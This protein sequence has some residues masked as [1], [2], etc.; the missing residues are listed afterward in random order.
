MRILHVT[1]SL[2]ARSGGTSEAIRLLCLGL[3]RHGAKSEVVTLDSPGSELVSVN[4]PVHCLGVTRSGYGCSTN[5]VPWLRQNTANYDAVIVH[6][7]WQ[8]GNLGV[9]WI[10]GGRCRKS[11]TDRLPPYFVFPHGMLDPWFKR[12]YWMKHLKKYLYWWLVESWVLRHAQAVLFT[13]DEERV[14][15]RQSFR[16]YFCREA[17][18]PL[19]IESPVGDIAQQQ[20]RFRDSVPGLGARR[21][22][23]FLGRLHPKKGPELA[24]QAFSRL[25]SQL[26]P[27]ARKEWAL[28]MAGPVAGSSVDPA[29]LGKLQ[30]LA[31][32]ATEGENCGSQILFPG[33]LLG[34][35]K[36]GGF[37]AC[38]AFILPS[39]QENFG[40][41]V[42]EALACG[43]PVLISD[44]VN[45]WR[46]I[47]DDGAA[48]VENDTEAGTLALL[49]RWMDLTESDKTSM[50]AR[51]RS[52]FERRFEVKAAARRLLELLT[53]SL[54]QTCTERSGSR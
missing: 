14:L 37:H 10:L 36:W 20:K 35:A 39:H 5:L 2:R 9:W 53:E 42:V 15:A 13:A 49:K 22:W 30:A 23:L 33:L 41:A 21:F 48:F 11:A 17:V 43:K 29:Y 26:P 28:V 50:G 16:P 6:G 1:R 52:C 38:E 3:F 51:A 47:Q 25:M 12:T 40:I 19:G 44:Q 7:L 8:F 46:E 27:D 4:C 31:S 18:V 54:Q 32:T 45:I 34:D 24:I